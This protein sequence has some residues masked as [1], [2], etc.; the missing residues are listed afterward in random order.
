MKRAARIALAL[1]VLLVGLYAQTGG[2]RLTVGFS[3]RPA[4][5]RVGDLVKFTD[6]SAGNPVEWLWDFGDGGTSPLQNPTH[7]YN[8]AGD[9]TLTVTITDSTGVSASVTINGHQ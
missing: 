8:T 7:V 4:F 2:N 1:L 6:Y 5:P 9:Y 3:Q